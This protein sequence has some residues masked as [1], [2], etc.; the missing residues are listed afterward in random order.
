M[1]GRSSLHSSFPSLIFV[2][3]IV[4]SNVP[5]L[6]ISPPAVV[7]VPALW[8]VPTVMDKPVFIPKGPLSFAE[9]I[10]RSQSSCL[11]SRSMAAQ[12]SDVHQCYYYE[13]NGQGICTTPGAG[14]ILKNGPRPTNAEQPIMAGGSKDAGGFVIL[15]NGGT[16]II[17]D[18]KKLGS[19]GTD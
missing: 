13:F 1:N 12:S 19:I 8:G 3:R 18:I 9:P 17:R 16:T 14:F 10:G 7:T 5:A 11:V 15:K 4:L 2:A 6:K